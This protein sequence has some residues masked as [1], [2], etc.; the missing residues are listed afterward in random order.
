MSYNQPPIHDKT[1][2]RPINLG[3]LRVSSVDCTLLTGNTFHVWSVAILKLC[4]EESYGG[5][6]SKPKHLEWRVSTL[7]KRTALI[8]HILLHHGPC[9]PNREAEDGQKGCTL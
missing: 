9:N 5:L 6:S 2:P 7:R 1:N 8:D 4:S 3:K